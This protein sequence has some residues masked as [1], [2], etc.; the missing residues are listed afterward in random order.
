MTHLTN[1][2]RAAHSLFP[3]RGIGGVFFLLVISAS[4]FSASCALP[5]SKVPA[6]ALD[7]RPLSLRAL[8]PAAKEGFLAGNADR[9]W[10]AFNPVRAG[11]ISRDGARNVIDQGAECTIRVMLAVEGSFPVTLS[12]GAVTVRDLGSDGALV[13]EPEKRPLAVADAVTG[14]IT[15]GIAVPRVGEKNGAEEN[16]VCGFAIA[17]SATGPTR[18][19]VVSASVIPA[20]TGWSRRGE[21]LSFAAPAPGGRIDAAAL[22][23]GE[24]FPVAVPEGSCMSFSFAPAGE[25]VGSILHQERVIFRTG[26][27]DFAFRKVPGPHV[28]AIPSFILSGS[29]TPVSGADTLSSLVVSPGKPLPVADLSAKSAP[30]QA[31]PSL[32]I[33]WPRDAWRRSEFEVFSWDSFPSVL[34]FDTADYAVQDLLFKRLAFYVEKEGYR[35]K[36]LGDAELAGLHAYNAHDYRAESLASFFDAAA[37]ADFALGDLEIELRDILVAE[38]V[39]V[40]RG[41]GFAAGAGAI[42]SISRESVPYLRYLFMAHEGYHGI[43]FVDPDFRAEV[44]RVFRSMDPRAIGFLETYFTVVDSLGYDTDDPYLMENEFMAYLMQQPL[45]RVG[46]YFTGVISE[47]YLRFGGE[48]EL[49]RYIA[50]TDASEFV[51]AASAL[52]DYAFSRW[53]LAGG[54]VGLYITE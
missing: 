27:K 19:R 21:A 38:G 37:K 2:S 30:I 4:L 35:G 48:K 45:D 29:V 52:N 51:R 17:F 15:L 26:G 6:A 1:N 46:A 33:E 24:G 18:V 20:E 42:I 54:R 10:F 31:D 25:S 13:R 28:T 47:R 43:Y 44:T 22:R 53:G 7:G 39:I 50:E 11:T 16:A 14:T 3:L 8:S 12:L 40:A 49:E 36:L 5:R 23:A 41:K 34:I 32:V 9:A